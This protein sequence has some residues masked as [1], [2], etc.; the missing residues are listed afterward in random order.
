MKNYK[1]K[2]L[3]EMNQFLKNCIQNIFPEGGRDNLHVPT[4]IKKLNLYFKN[5]SK[6]KSLDSTISQWQSPQNV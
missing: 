2:I 6:K 3:E 5:F 4:T 1:F